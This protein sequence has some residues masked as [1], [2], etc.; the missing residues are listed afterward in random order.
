MRVTQNPAWSVFHDK[1]G[2]RSMIGKMYLSGAGV[3][4]DPGQAERWL[5]DAGDGDSL[6]Q[7]YKL[8]TRGA[9]PENAGNAEMPLL[10]AAADAGSANAQHDLAQRY[11]DGRGVPVSVDRAMA[12]RLKGRHA[13]MS[14][15]NDSEIFG[16]L[17]DLEET[18]DRRNPSTQEIR[19]GAAAGDPVALERL[20]LSYFDRNDNPG[21]VVAIA[22]FG[23]VAEA[24]KP[25]RHV[26]FDQAVL[27]G[28]HADPAVEAVIQPLIDSAH[29]LQ[30]EMSG[31]K[32]V[33]AS[34]DEFIS[35]EH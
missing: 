6:L 21:Y 20:A 18:P 10:I 30:A 22:L 23:F 14:D 35:N 17:L 12:Y 29:Q 8:R 32:G 7:V 5:L 19:A 31:Q 28:T 11:L 25:G 33:L 3:V 13:D 15:A 4:Q 34:I 26:A 24:N 27:D 9:S 2:V 16:P 1:A